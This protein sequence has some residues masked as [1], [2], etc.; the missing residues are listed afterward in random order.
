MP[1]KDEPTFA[2]TVDA[3]VTDTTGETLFRRALRPGGIHR[4]SGI[5]DRR[6]VADPGLA[7]RVRR[8]DEVA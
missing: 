8:R 2:F 6:A 5:A 3:D 7:G 4:A 1:A